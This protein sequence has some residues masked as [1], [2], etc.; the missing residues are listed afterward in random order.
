MLNKLCP[1]QFSFGFLFGCSGLGEFDIPPLFFFCGKEGLIH[2]DDCLQ[3]RIFFLV[4]SV[5][6]SLNPGFVKCLEFH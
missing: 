1:F 2:Y 4:K 6:L 3:F 5:S